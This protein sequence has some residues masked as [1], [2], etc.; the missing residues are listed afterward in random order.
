M[1][2]FHFLLNRDFYAMCLELGILYN[3]EGELPETAGIPRVFILKADAQGNEKPV[4]VREAG[5]RPGSLEFWKQA[6]L[7]NVFM[8]P[9]GKKDP[10]QLQMEDNN[11]ELRLL[12]GISSYRA[13]C[14]EYRPFPSGS[15]GGSHSTLRCAACIS[16]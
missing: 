6:E 7:G 12:K 5:I 15:S 9:A 14:R 13:G 4:S 3:G 11:G 8:Y 1:S 2:C 10:V 16:P